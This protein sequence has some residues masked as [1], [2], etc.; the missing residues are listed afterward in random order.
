MPDIMLNNKNGIINDHDMANGLKCSRCG[1]ATPEMN[2]DE[3]ICFIGM[4]DDYVA[5][6]ADA[7]NNAK[8][9]VKGMQVIYTK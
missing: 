7:I 6:L 8:V 4:L 3:L 9:K 1:K 2:R 5:S